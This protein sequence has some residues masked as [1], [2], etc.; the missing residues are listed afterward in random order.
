MLRLLLRAARVIPPALA[1][2]AGGLLGRVV[3][4]LPLRDV[5]RCGEHLAQAFPE[6]DAAW[7][8]RT[9]VRCFGHFGSTMLWSIATWT[10]EQQRLRRGL[11]VEGAEH[12]RALVRAAKAGEGTVVFTGHFGNWELLAR[13]FGGLTPAAMIGRRLR[14]PGL[15]ALVQGMRMSGGAT[16]IYQDDDIRDIVRLLRG[17]TTVATLADQDVPH[18]AGCFVPWFGIPAWTPVAPAALALLARVPVQVLLLH[19]RAGRWVLHV[20]PRRTVARGAD[21]TAAQHDITAWATA[22]EEA[23]VREQPE[24]WVWWHKRWRTRPAAVV[25]KAADSLAAAGA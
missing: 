23:L 19:R 20:S 4:R 8:A 11:V 7:I 24:Q 14:D 1:W 18:L 15:N 5:R 13:V 12:L 22:Y 25:A 6:C 17:G 9:R 10:Y 3:G 16:L 2:R 21:R